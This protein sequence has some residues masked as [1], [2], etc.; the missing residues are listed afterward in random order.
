MFQKI[1]FLFFNKLEITKKNDKKI[2]QRND[3][4]KGQYGYTANPWFRL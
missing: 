2:P 4:E 1:R 3:R